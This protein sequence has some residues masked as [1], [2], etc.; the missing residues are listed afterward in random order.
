MNDYIV[1]ISHEVE[2]EMVETV[3]TLVMSHYPEE[4]E[5]VTVTVGDE[6]SGAPIK[7]TGAVVVVF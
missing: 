4:G 1:V 7:H 5:T 6:N 3:G 2:G